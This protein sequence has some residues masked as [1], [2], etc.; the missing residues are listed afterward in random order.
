MTDIREART[1][2]DVLSAITG[3]FERFADQYGG[4]WVSAPVLQPLSLLLDLTG[5]ALRAQLILVSGGAEDMALRTDF[6]IPVV[7]GHI[8]SGAAAGRY[9]YA[10]DVYR[11]PSAGKPAEVFQ[12]GL[13]IFGLE[14]DP[15]AEDGAVI[16]LAYSA[17]KSGG[18][19]DLQL[20]VGDIALFRAFLGALG[21]PE[22]TAARLVRALPNPR[23]LARE[24]D[25]AAAPAGETRG[26][27]AA[28]LADLPEN[29]AA[30][31]LEELW[32]LAG[33]QPVGGRTPA[34]IVHRLTLREEAAKNPPLTAAERDLIR[35]YLAISAPLHTALS[36]V[37]A[38]AAEAG[39][40]VS[41]SVA[42]WIERLKTMTLSGVDPDLP[43]LATGFARPFGYYDGMLFEVTSPSLGGDE[44]IAAGGR[45]DGLPER[46]GGV[47]GAIGC[48]VRPAL[49]WSG[50]VKAGVA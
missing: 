24:L 41:R 10:G 6:T 15:V 20:R 26:R 48:M 29:E 45:Y 31:M 27:L 34:E 49:A 40:D 35:R 17:A 9:L 21:L 13:E 28:I 8:A 32:R 44:A 18:R 33:I 30:A 38:L 4:E 25:R 36:Q 42:T 19:T 7:R 2:D 16:G 3:P 50:T 12:L 14:A 46:L 39:G 23:L 43:V 37:E 1:P 5:E 47:R 11:A 22:P